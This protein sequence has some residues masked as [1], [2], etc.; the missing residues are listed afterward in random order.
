V[1][2]SLAEKW[3]WRSFLDTLYGDVPTLCA[4]HGTMHGMGEP[5]IFYVL[6]KDLYDYTNV[7]WMQA[8]IIEKLHQGQPVFMYY[9]ISHRIGIYDYS[10]TDDDTR[11]VAARRWLEDL[12]FGKMAPHRR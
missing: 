6:A 11:L 1:L 8:T 9:L 7:F 5:Q 4:L 12:K 2:T 10:S 3:K